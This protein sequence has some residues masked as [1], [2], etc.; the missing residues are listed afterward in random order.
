MVLLTWPKLE[1]EAGVQ[2]FYRE[3][4]QLLPDR[5][6]RATAVHVL[7]CAAFLA[8]FHA[9]YSECHTP[10]VVRRQPRADAIAPAAWHAFD[11]DL[12]TDCEGVTRMP[13]WRVHAQ[14]PVTACRVLSG[15]R[16]WSDAGSGLA[17]ADVQKDL[18]SHLVLRGDEHAVVGGVFN[19][20]ELDRALLARLRVRIERACVEAI[21]LPIPITV[22]AAK[23][24]M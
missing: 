1:S 16:Y 23:A 14:A 18:V 2:C 5:R 19:N 17:K 11:V 9:L 22:L 3:H 12:G 6:R 7:N 20:I 21:G 24:G 8:R 13:T 10:S 4:G 15:G